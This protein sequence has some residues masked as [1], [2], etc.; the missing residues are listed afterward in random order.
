[1][2]T[3]GESQSMTVT[4]GNDRSFCHFIRNSF[5]NLDHV[6]KIHIQYRPKHWLQINHIKQ[7]WYFHHLWPQ[8]QKDQEAKMRKLAQYLLRY[9]YSTFLKKKGWEL[10]KDMYKL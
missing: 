3:P 8:N 1:M 10:C 2:R 9:N 5:A 6:I 4:C 7:I